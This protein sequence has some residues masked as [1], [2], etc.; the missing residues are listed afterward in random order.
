MKPPIPRPNPHRMVPLQRKRPPHQR[1]QKRLTNR[2]RQNI[3]LLRKQPS[4]RPA[5]NRRQR[6][7]HRIRPMQQSKN[8]SSRNRRPNRTLKR[9]HQPVGHHRIQPNLLDHAEQEITEE[10]L[11][12]RHMRRRSILHAQKKSANN[13]GHNGGK[14]KVRK[15]A[16][17]RPEIIET[18]AKRGQAIAPHQKARHQPNYK[19]TPRRPPQRLQPPDIQ[20]NQTT[21][22]QRLQNQSTP[23]PVPCHY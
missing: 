1:P 22:R 6:H 10:P 21:K 18:P 9:R 2:Q 20:P 5:R 19:Q 23:I 14:K 7:Q 12:L 11:W 17:S 16:R 4:H 13:H 3:P 8:S 15:V